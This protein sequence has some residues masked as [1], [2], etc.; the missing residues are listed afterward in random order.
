MLKLRNIVK[1]V[2]T[3]IFFYIRGQDHPLTLNQCL[4]YFDRF[5]LSGASDDEFDLWPVYSGERP[6]ALWLSCFDNFNKGE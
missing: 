4:S 3:R 2:S 1:Q 5:K 6:M